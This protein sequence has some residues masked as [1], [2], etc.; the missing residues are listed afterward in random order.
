M[1]SDDGKEAI[2]RTSFESEAKKKSLEL[3]IQGDETLHYTLTPTSARALE[4][5]IASP[6]RAMQ[7]CAHS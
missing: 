4:V 1:S 5:S 7:S 6:K 3:L 2:R